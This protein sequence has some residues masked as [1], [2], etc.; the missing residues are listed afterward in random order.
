MFVALAIWVYLQ[1]VKL[2]SWWKIPLIGFFLAAAILLRRHFAY[3]AIAFFGAATLQAFIE[4]IVLIYRRETAL[5]YRRETALPCPKD[6]ET[7]LPFPYRCLFESGVKLGLIATTS[8]T[9]LMLVAGD[10]T[11]SALTVDYRNL[12]VAWSL[13]V[14]D[15]LSR[16]ADFYGLGT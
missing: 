8:L 9:I 12:Y 10:F 5:K 1:D 4:F 3:S 16:Y 2:K 15:I 7:A 13:P 6:Q 14:N 11:R